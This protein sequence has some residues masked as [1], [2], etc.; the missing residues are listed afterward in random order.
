MS[1]LLAIISFLAAASAAAA[2]QI[3]DVPLEH[4]F[5]NGPFSRTGQFTGELDLQVSP[6]ATYTKGSPIIKKMGRL[7]RYYARNMI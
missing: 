4:A 5:G 2:S 3:V 6:L 7:L 1:L